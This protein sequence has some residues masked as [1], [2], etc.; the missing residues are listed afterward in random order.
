VFVDTNILVCATQATSPHRVAAHRGLQRFSATEARM[1]LS[2]QVLRE[3]LSVVTRP[4]LFLNPVP[5]A[6]A[7]D[8]V[9][10]FASSFEILKDGPEVGER[11]LDLCRRV[12]LAGRQVHDA[13]IV[14]TMLAHGEDRLLTMNC[15]DFRRF[16]PHIEIVEP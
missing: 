2:R 12:T 11:L 7:L 15:S 5:I 6:E 14:A 13:N 8:D 10:R 16:Q 4:Q 9:V 3:Y 1:C